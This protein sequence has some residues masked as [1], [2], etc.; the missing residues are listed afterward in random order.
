MHAPLQHVWHDRV[1][2]VSGR[3]SA[4]PFIATELHTSTPPDLPRFAPQ[5]VACS[6]CLS[7]AQRC[8]AG[9]QRGLIR[10]YGA[11]AIHEITSADATTACIGT[12]LSL[13]NTWIT[14]L[15]EALQPCADEEEGQVAISG[16]QLARGYLNHD[17]LSA[18]KFVLADGRRIYLTGDLAVRTSDGRIEFRGR[19]DSQARFRSAPHRHWALGAAPMPSLAFALGYAC[20]LGAC[21]AT[22]RLAAVVDGQSGFRSS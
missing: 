17:E 2:R 19:V 16:A 14:V 8:G 1:H 12:A 21:Q 22:A 9:A 4:V 18:R 10:K 13:A 20:C 7:V 11:Q 6:L 3:L 15:N 5:R